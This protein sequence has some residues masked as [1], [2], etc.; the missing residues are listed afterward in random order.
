MQA[1]SEALVRSHAWSVV[2][3]TRVMTFPTLP[4]LV[5][6][7]E[8]SSALVPPRLC[9]R[10][11][12]EE[13]SSWD[14]RHRWCSDP[15]PCGGEPRAILPPWRE[16]NGAIVGECTRKRA[17][18]IDHISGGGDEGSGRHMG[19]DAIGEQAGERKKNKEGLWSI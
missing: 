5:L 13:E 18:E 12:S 16:K 6:N 9:A 2:T 17:S 15:P 3:L 8:A 10:F 11:G 1:S 19:V 4:P 7:F 14:G